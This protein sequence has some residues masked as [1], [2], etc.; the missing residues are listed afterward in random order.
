MRTSPSVAP[1]GLEQDT[2]LVLDNF[3]GRQDRSWRETDEAHA[4]RAAVIIDLLDGQYN[5]PV[6]VIAFNAGEGWCR[7]VS[8]EIADLVVQECGRKGH[9]IP[10]FLQSFVEQRGS[11]RAV[12]R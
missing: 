8:Q 9:H 7:D 11:R 5:D 4:D 6:R 10:S 1:V 12:P 3:G 2:Y